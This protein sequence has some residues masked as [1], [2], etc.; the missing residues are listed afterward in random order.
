MRSA[1]FPDKDR[2]KSLHFPAASGQISDTV[3]VPA[4]TDRGAGWPDSV[5]IRDQNPSI[6][7]WTCGNL[8]GTAGDVAAFYYDL[9]APTATSSERIV[10]DAARDEMCRFELQTKGW[11]AGWLSYGAGLMEQVGKEGAS[12]NSSSPSKPGDWNYYIG[13]G[14]LTYGFSA[15]QGYIP[16][17]GAA[18][19]VVANTDH[20]E[21]V[22]TAR[23][24][25]F[26]AA[27]KF[28][29]GE[30]IYF[31]CKS[32]GKATANTESLFEIIV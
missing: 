2:Y 7:G 18:F 32:F 30:E 26:E 10:S 17:L 19:V 5:V 12:M 21:F 4:I 3:T 23:C 29:K 16:K 28:L 22:F 24:R 20:Q 11:G 9:L 13:H 25:V 8:V 1:A 6:L 31:N 14:G 27:A 15:E